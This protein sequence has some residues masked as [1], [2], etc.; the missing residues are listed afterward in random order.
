[1]KKQQTN[2]DPQYETSLALQKNRHSETHDIRQ[3][4]CE[5]QVFEGP[6]ATPSNGN[7][8]RKLFWN[9]C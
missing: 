6:F 2:R 9:L 7:F 8:K 5:T 1:M 3:K 4:F